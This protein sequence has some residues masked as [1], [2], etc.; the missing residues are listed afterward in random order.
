VIRPL[1]KSAAISLPLRGS[2]AT[3]GEGRNAAAE[4]GAA[5][6]AKAPVVRSGWLPARRV[7]CRAT[8]RM[9]VLRLMDTPASES[10]SRIASHE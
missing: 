1:T 10:A 4:E 5:S 3:S 2:A 8:S 7:A 9:T 6:V